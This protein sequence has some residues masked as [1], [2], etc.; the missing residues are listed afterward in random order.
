MCHIPLRLVRVIFRDT[1]IKVVSMFE[2]CR[3]L[4]NVMSFTGANGSEFIKVH[5]NDP[6]LVNCGKMVT[7]A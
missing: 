3:L 4:C 1:H 7:L 5:T 6:K 2:I